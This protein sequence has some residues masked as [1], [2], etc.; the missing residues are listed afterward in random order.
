[1]RIGK[2]VRGGRT[3]CMLSRMGGGEIDPSPSLSPDTVVYRAETIP[4]LN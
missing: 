4:D 2:G 3:M 1:M